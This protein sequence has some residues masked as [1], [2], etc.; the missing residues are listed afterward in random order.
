MLGDSITDFYDLD[1]YYGSEELIV[2]NVRW[3]FV[4]INKK[5][6]FTIHYS[7]FVIH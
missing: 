6:S 1:K 5:S 2:N 7:L 3:F 4:D